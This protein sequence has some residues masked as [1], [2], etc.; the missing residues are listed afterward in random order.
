[1]E[2][3]DSNIDLMKIYTLVTCIKVG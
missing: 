3:I 1:M 2:H